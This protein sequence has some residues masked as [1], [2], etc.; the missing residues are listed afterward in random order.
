MTEVNKS[1]F[2]TLNLI[3]M[4]Q[5]KKVLVAIALVVGM[6][7][8]VQAQ[9]SKV[10]H[11]NTQ[12]LVEAMPSYKAALADLEKLQRSYDS[13]ISEMGTELQKTM[14]RYGREVETQTDE[15]NL[16]RQKEVQET[17]QNIVAY[18][19]NA[20]K[21]LQTKEQDLLKPLLEQARVAIQKVARAK[22]FQFVLDST[23]GA[24]GVIMADGYNLMGDVKA[25]L[26]I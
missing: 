17:N 16:R 3:T 23:P 15:E 1:N 14:E 4:K 2:I 7:G 12:E 10:A 8:A 11:I 5:I 13:Q 24:G 20:L 21:D 19:Q 26:G 22:G 9:E 25:D 6:T 18:R